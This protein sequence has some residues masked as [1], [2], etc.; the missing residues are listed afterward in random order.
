MSPYVPAGCQRAWP[1]PGTRCSLRLDKLAT[2]MIQVAPRDLAL[3][4]LITVVWGFNVIVSKVG[5]AEI[6]PVLFTF[7]RFALVAVLLVPTLRVHRGQ[8]SALTV[9]A[10]LSGA[11]NF[12]LS[13]V[14][15][16]LA[17]NVSSVAIAGQ[18][19]V[20]FTT[21]LSV[22]LLGEIVRWRRLLGIIL[23]F[24]GVLVIGFDPQ[25][26]ARWESLAFVVGSALAASLGVIAVKK[27]YGFKPLELQAWLAWISLPPLLLISLQIEQ[28]DLE[29]LAQVSWM[30]WGAVFFTAVVSSICAHTGY[31]YLIQRYP[32]TSVAPLT[33]LS[34]IF[35]ILFGIVLLGDDLSG[36]T[37]LGAALTLAGVFIITL[38]E[39]RIVDTGT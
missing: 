7:L 25:M 23:A 35:T 37:A 16:K 2:P 6:P 9:A 26:L 33:T 20:P 11:L 4:L 8:M 15:V 12:A 31:F 5:L 38:R 14:G 34:P 18:L 10:L 29:A 28:P 36:R 27:L 19:S 30:A 13:F 32:L 22:A 3:L 1:Y 17:P 24:G 39:R 21:L